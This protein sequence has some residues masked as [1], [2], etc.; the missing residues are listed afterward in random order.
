MWADVKYALRQLRKS[1]GFAATAI[2]TLAIGI[3]ANA[4]VFSVLNALVLRPLALPHSDQLV[5]LER[6]P[7]E[8]PTQS[9]LDY[10]D[11]RDQ[12]AT[13]SGLAAYR[14]SAGALDTGNNPSA[15]WF[16][17]ASGNYFDVAGIQPYL[18]RFFH[19]A[20]E[21][22]PDSAPYAVLSYGYWRS[23]FAGDPQIVGKTIQI[24]KRPFSVIGVAPEKFRGTELFFDPALWVPIVNE[25]QIDGWNFLDDRGDHTLFV[26]GRLKPGVSVVAAESDLNAISN[27]LAAQYP[28]E[29]QSL[30][31]RLARPGLVGNT[32][33]RPV[34]AFL[35]GVMLLAALILLATCANLG[36]LF[37]ARAAD[38]SR[39]MAIR[40][41][42]GSTRE[43][44]LRQLLA[45]AVLLSLAGGVLGVQAAAML[46]RWLSGW[47]V[48]PD[49]P[50]Q[51]PVSP[52]ASTYM[53]ALLLS[54]FS[55]VLFGI[56][57]VRQVFRADA[58]Q[59]VKAGASSA[60]VWRKLTMRDVLLM[61]QIAVCAVLVTSSLVA[62]R[63]LLRSLHSNF[64]FS[65][66]G[67]MLAK[68][69]LQDAGYDEVKTQRFQRQVLDAVK[70]IP[71]VFEAGYINHPPLGISNSD[72][73]VYR[74]GTTDFK[75][76]NSVADAIYY[77]T[78]PGYFAVAQTTML[79]GRD[80]SWHDDA[81]SPRVAVINETFARKV[82]GS[83]RGAVGGYFLRGSGDRIQV[84]GVVQDGKYRTLT[85][86]QQP[87][88]FF[89]ILQDTDTEITLVVRS[90]R[91]ASQTAAALQGTVASLDP[92]LPMTI[93]SWPAAM[94]SA[95]FAARAA[96]VALGV[97]GM[98]GAMLAVTGIFGMASYSVSKRMR[99]L[100][101]R[102]ALGARRTEVIQ[103][104]LGRSLKLLCAG[105]MAGLLLG[106]AASKVL[107]A[108]VYQA[109]PRDP[110][111][112]AGVVI[113]MVLLGTIAAWLPARRAAS[114][115]P[116]ILLR[117]E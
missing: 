111:I 96:T 67:A 76:L 46:L 97:M 106:M 19:A 81:K 42:L 23:H 95:L 91:S 31:I 89:P 50:I 12:A 94:D 82:F 73:L 39:E 30:K 98:L 34:R 79:A 47:H 10:R 5:F 83:G 40:M 110:L 35:G 100:G 86:E 6:M 99:E 105:S 113:V 85:E 68:F 92:G 71:G 24:N 53:V 115:D 13:F 65:P 66:A 63:G 58:Y 51:V 90:N 26:I 102:V 21:H 49:S 7:V 112:I 60:R 103:A 109:T 4:V 69:D 16:Y 8:S 20:D 32:L 108:V 61:V 87:A 15:I 38:R 57:P 33:G 41:A 44:I 3:G 37:A 1:P 80:F 88:M 11:M 62:V 22:G 27:R 36:S 48:I 45:E 28:K 116:A 93:E 64:G 43:R 25:K 29:D 117:E 101:I 70:A 17:E 84:I 56:T 107:E 75:P 55:G 114:V 72:T 52:D 104:A 14:F 2:L 78:S 9:Y 54:I 59:L 74:N 77:K 18:G